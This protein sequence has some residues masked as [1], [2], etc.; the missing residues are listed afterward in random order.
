[1]NRAVYSAAPQEPGVRGID[2]RIH[3]KPR[4]V[5]AYDFQPRMRIVHSDS[6]VASYGA[7]AVAL[8]EAPDWPAA[9]NATTPYQYRAPDVTT[10]VNVVTF[11]PT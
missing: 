3:I 10:S 6:S 2:D 11:A 5:A 8:F 7:I 4:N 1:M 9:L